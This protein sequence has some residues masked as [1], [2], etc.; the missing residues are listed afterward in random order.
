MPARFASDAAVKGSP[1]RTAAE[2]IRTPDQRLRVFVSSTLDELAAER[3]ATR[4]AVTGLQLT[5]VVFEAGA[6][7][8]PARDL[9]RA[10]LSQ[11]DVFIG[12]YWQSYGRISP[13]MEVSGLEE[14]YRL[15]QGKP[16]LIYIKRPSP[17]REPRLQTFLD[18]IRSDDV[19]SYQKFSTPEELQQLVAN[20]LAQ[21]LTERFIETQGASRAPSARFSP[22][23][24]PRSSLIDR[25]GEVAKA[26][27]LL[28]RDD[29][30][31]LTLTGPAGVGKT[32]LAI[33]VATKSADQFPHG[34]AFISLAPLRDH[35]LVI[36]HLSRALQV[37]GDERREPV[38][39]SVLEYLHNRHLLLVLD[40]GEQ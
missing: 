33:E 39:E 28:L 11:S 24:T 27:E 22:L 9:Y 4:D 23:P 25:V 18:R 34:A 32:R 16:Q 2:R 12:I 40:N 29:L 3:R 20:D 8:Y 36:P 38:R 7:P 13:G 30:G 21:L 35:R 37:S 26:R 15:A 6:R 31:L 1:A 10:Y 19:T 14:E 5:P 17:E